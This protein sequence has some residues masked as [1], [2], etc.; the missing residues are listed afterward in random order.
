MDQRRIMNSINIIYII[1]CIDF[2]YVFR[3]PLF[4]YEYTSTICSYF[5]KTAFFFFSSSRN[6]T[7]RA[8][9]VQI[10]STYVVVFYNRVIDCYFFPEFENQSFFTDTYAFMKTSFLHV[11]VTHTIIIGRKVQ[12]RRYTVSMTPPETCIYIHLSW[13]INGCLNVS[14]QRRQRWIRNK[15]EKIPKTKRKLY[16]KFTIRISLL[17]TY[18]KK[19][20]FSVMSE[21]RIVIGFCTCRLY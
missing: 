13:T 14:V 10:Y 11:P 16:R 17:G 3:H 6:A 9:T 8:R 20:L 12:A 19:V 15:L 1:P 2:D 21:N 18:E 5:Y 7:I 4:V